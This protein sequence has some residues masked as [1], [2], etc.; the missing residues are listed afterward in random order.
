MH[1]DSIRMHK[2]SLHAA[3]A[4]LPPSASA[5][6]V[7]YLFWAF[8]WALDIIIEF[9]HSLFFSNDNLLNADDSSLFDD[10]S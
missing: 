9:M 6:A 8:L 7:L 3:A 5:Y 2:E 4:N 10:R 1:M